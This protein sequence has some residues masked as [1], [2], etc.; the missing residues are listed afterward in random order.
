MSGTKPLEPGANPLTPTLS[1]EIGGKGYR[2]ARALFPHEIGGKAGLGGLRPLVFVAILP[3]LLAPTSSLAADP[4]P[5]P[6]PL[7]ASIICE[8]PPTPGRFRCDVELRTAAGRFSWADTQVVK[9]YDFILPLRGRLGP[10]DAATHEPDLYRWSLGFVAKARGT[11]EV[12]LR[13]RAVVCQGTLCDP[14]ETEIRGQV[15]VG[16]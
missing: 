8:S 12:T 13:V 16:R 2:G 10:M 3:W 1:P 9:V 5:P 4:A 15:V 7:R 14:V 11:G 6:S